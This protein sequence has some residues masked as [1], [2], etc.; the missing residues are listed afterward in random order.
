MNFIDL[1]GTGL[2]TLWVAR[3]QYQGICCNGRA[4]EVIG[5]EE[6]GA[7]L[8]STVCPLVGVPVLLTKLAVQKKS[9]TRR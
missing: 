5:P 9:Y 4:Q 1:V 8:R 2:K 3:V 7:C 6:L